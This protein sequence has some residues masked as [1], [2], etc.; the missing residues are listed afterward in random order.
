MAFTYIPKIE[1]ITNG[2]S[3]TAT[4]VTLQDT[5]GAYNVSTNPGGYGTPNPASPAS[6]TKAYILWR[7]WTD[8]SYGT[9]FTLS[10]G[11]ITSLQGAG[12]AITPL[13]QGLSTDSDAVFSDGIHQIK[14]IPAQAL[15]GTGTFT[16]SSKIVVLSG[17]SGVAA[18]Q[19]LGGIV[20]VLVVI[21][22]TTYA[23]ELD[24]TGTN[25]NTQLTL[26][27]AVTVS[28]GAGAT[29]IVGGEDDIKILINKAAEACIVSSTGALADIPG[30]CLEVEATL[31]KM[32]R[33]QFAANIQY[34][35]EDYDGA[36]NLVV[37]INKYCTSGKCI[38][39]S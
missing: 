8:T 4:S 18:L 27:T 19:A 25:D 15:A 5:T 14:Y 21:A 30:S 39:N 38:C 6:T 2:I 17:S 9:P 29:V 26:K 24:T 1:L 37:S 7:Y 23:Y 3:K 13:M 11:N 22:G 28:S 32:I 16:A 35:C 31:N 20:W 12:L 36:H 34:E 33:W 10:A